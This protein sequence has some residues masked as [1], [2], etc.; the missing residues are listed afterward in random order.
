MRTIFA[1]IVEETFFYSWPGY[2]GAGKKGDW[3]LYSPGFPKMPLEP[4][5]GSHK[6]LSRRFWPISIRKPDLGP[7]L[8]NFY[9]D[10]GFGLFFS[11][12]TLPE[13]N[14]LRFMHHASF[15]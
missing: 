3:L 11:L 4:L 8:V 9:P 1:A 15:I 7:D 10:A 2:R 13:L 6:F 5:Y 12:D 14:F